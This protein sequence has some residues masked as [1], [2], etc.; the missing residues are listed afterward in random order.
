MN[1]NDFIS[2]ISFHPTAQSATRAHHTLKCASLDEQVT[3]P[4]EKNF[5]IILTWDVHYNLKRRQSEWRTNCIIDT[6][7]LPFKSLTILC[8][9]SCSRSPLNACSLHLLCVSKLNPSQSPLLVIQTFLFILASSSSC[10]PCGT[11]PRPIELLYLR[12]VVF[13]ASVDHI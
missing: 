2:T 11:A 13:L 5:T 8:C 3:N 10:M 6:S 4:K 9:D 7:F 1:T 12:F